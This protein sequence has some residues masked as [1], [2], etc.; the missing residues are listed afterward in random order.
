M[1]RSIWMCWCKPWLLIGLQLI[2]V[3]ATRN[4]DRSNL[5]PFCVSA[6]GALWTEP[7]SI[8]SLGTWLVL[9]RKRQL[10]AFENFNCSMGW[11]AR[12]G[13]YMFAITLTILRAEVLRE[14]MR[15]CMH[16]SWYKHE[17]E[18]KENIFGDGCSQSD[19]SEMRC[20]KESEEADFL[21][22]LKTFCAFM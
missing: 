13:H 2:H 6:C 16:C 20:K 9:G 17:L 8:T 10:S 21:R 22:C 11:W 12:S 19:F 18:S 1:T 3:S 4:I 5:K 7:W 15:M 14:E